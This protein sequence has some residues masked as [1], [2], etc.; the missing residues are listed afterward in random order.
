MEQVLL[1]LASLMKI[2]VTHCGD[3]QTLLGITV[4]RVLTGMH[5]FTF[6]I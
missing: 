5:A 3:F 4:A 2:Q 1:G 6:H